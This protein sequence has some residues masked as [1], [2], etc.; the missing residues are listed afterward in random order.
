VGCRNVKTLLTDLKVRP[1]RWGGEYW[2]CSFVKSN[3]PGR[4]EKQNGCPGLYCQAHSAGKGFLGMARVLRMFQNGAFL[5]FCWKNASRFLGCLVNALMVETRTCPFILNTE[6]TLYGLPLMV[7]SYENSVHVNGRAGA[8]P[9]VR[10][11]FAFL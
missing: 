5:D 2:A 4:F 1:V 6:V 10:T 3:P 8:G 7:F 9:P 11:V